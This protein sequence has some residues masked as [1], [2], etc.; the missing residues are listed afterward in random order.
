M[1]APSRGTAAS[2][3]RTPPRTETRHFRPQP[4][5]QTG[6]LFDYLDLVDCKE[7]HPV[8]LAI[9]EEAL[10]FYYAGWLREPSDATPTS[11]GC[12]GTAGNEADSLYRHFCI[13]RIAFGSRRDGSAPH[14]PESMLGERPYEAELERPVAEKWEP[15]YGY[16]KYWPAAEAGN[17][18]DALAR[19][20]FL[21]FLFDLAHERTF[22]ES[23]PATEIERCLLR[24]PGATAI[25]RKAEYLWSKA[26]IDRSSGAYE[27]AFVLAEREWVAVCTGRDAESL[28]RER[29]T[30]F[31]D[32][33]SEAR[34]VAFEDPQPD[35]NAGSDDAEDRG[36]DRH[37]R[38]ME[39][40]KWFLGRYDL[41]AAVL[42]L[43]HDLRNGPA[44]GD[45]P[46][47]RLIQS[48][49]V[50]GGSL[51]LM[52]ALLVGFAKF[53]RTAS[54][55]SLPSLAVHVR[56][57]G[58][59]MA[60]PAVFLLAPIILRRLWKKDAP[61]RGDPARSIDGPRLFHPARR[62]VLV[63]CVFVA[64]LYAVGDLGA[65][66]RWRS[67]GGLFRWPV[68]VTVALFLIVGLAPVAI[69]FVVRF[70]VIFQRTIQSWSSRKQTAP[71]ETEVA[72]L[73]RSRS[74]RRQKVAAESTCGFTCCCRG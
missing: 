71:G 74:S 64:G 53:G 37:K 9:H 2:A 8:Y 55:V 57:Y 62:L 13:C 67:A 59:V 48:P 11:A 73:A 61:S 26:M 27:M 36:N 54:S 5:D 70:S 51:G 4:G 34:K 17:E 29:P 39:L 40:A 24:D 28:F 30:W 10:E 65:L 66:E 18:K 45:G 44:S 35:K 22:H 12:A 56:W 16:A 60:A 41:D 38:K 68:V 15:E 14:L 33:E 63:S 7:T 31:L 69:L 50:F 43:L 58:L 6:R 21:D 42:L 23:F 52:V 47:W 1:K 3:D 20:L 32:V 49:W 72:G 25:L 19:R 46:L